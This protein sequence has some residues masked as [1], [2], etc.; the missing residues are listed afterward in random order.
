M[1]QLY[2]NNQLC[3]LY[4]NETIA[5]DYS[6]A[7]IGNISSRTSAKSITFK[8]PLTANNRAIIENANVIVNSTVLPYRLIPCQL[9]ANGLDQNLEFAQIK[10]IQDDISIALY[11]SN[12][13]FFSII[14]SL[15]LSDLG[16]TFDHV[17]NLANAFAS[18]TNTD[19]YI[20]AMIDY[21]TDSPNGYID[22]TTAQIDVRGLRPSF[23]LHSAIDMIV[24]Q[25]G[26]TPQGDILTDANYMSE[27]LPLT[28][29][30]T[31][32]RFVDSFDFVAGATLGM[33]NIIPLVYRSGIDGIIL[34]QGSTVTI[35]G[36]TDSSII[37]RLRTKAD[38]TLQ[39][40]A[41][42]WFDFE[43]VEAV[44][45]TYQSG[46]P[47]VLPDNV[48]LFVVG[49]NYNITFDL[50]FNNS[51][52]GSIDF[53]YGFVYDTVFPVFGNITAI[54]DVR[55]G[56]DFGSYISIAGTLPD[57]KQSDLLKDTAQKFGLIFQVDNQRKIVH[58]R[59][60]SEILDNVD[61]ALDWSDKVDY[62]EK[63]EI[64]FDSDYAQRN[65]CTYKEDETVVKPIGTDSEILIDND[66]LTAE[67]KLFESPFSASERVM[68]FNGVSI[69]Q[70][71]IFTDL[72]GADEGIAD[73]I[74]RY[75]IKREV[76]FSPAF[77]WTDGTGTETDFTVPVTHFILAGESFNNGFA[78][79][80][81]PLYSS[82][83]IALIQ[84][85]KSVKMLLR[86]NAADINQ[87]DFFIPVW[88]ELNGQPGCYFYISEIKQFKVT[89]KES[90][91]V[92]LTKL[93]T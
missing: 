54:R 81:L 40:A 33:T 67:K 50:S 30:F 18:R 24:K 28:N 38:I 29:S 39:A 11:G 69:A 17:W 14:K 23:Y 85:F 71:K 56:N 90:T 73:V 57:M 15:K 3:D 60:F 48:F 27:L 72:G 55:F 10:S 77:T 76:T 22:N 66:N 65:L 8:L 93:T 43:V 35:R 26:F 20:Y 80:L 7:P 21:F 63:P 82:D 74:P 88:I 86:L 19:G 9:L 51:T 25:A 87:I 12:I 46:I 32:L 44:G 34:K 59:R 49:D 62:S 37:L 91:S 92:T 84:N 41:I 16:N 78:N 47:F 6:I 2:L 45:L 31:D 1:V 52:G 61:N 5:T 89:A 68:R 4:G 53:D 79:N 70:I 75:L 42:A 36:I 83:I 64:E 13:D 58:I